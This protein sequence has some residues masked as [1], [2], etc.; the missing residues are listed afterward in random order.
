[1]NRFATIHR[2]LEPI[3][4]RT[5]G[6]AAYKKVSNILTMIIGREHDFLVCNMG[7]ETT[8]YK[9]IIHLA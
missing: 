7:I 1:M 6:T 9:P 8:N 2:G 5:D 3:G 4:Y